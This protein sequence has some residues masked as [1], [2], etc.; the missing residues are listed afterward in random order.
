MKIIKWFFLFSISTLFLACGASTDEQRADAILN[1]MYYIESGDC[2]QAITLLE[3]VGRDMENFF[4][5][6]ALASSYAC[7]A[8]YSTAGLFDDITAHFGSPSLLGGFSLFSNASI[9]VSPDTDSSFVALQE[10]IDILLFAGGV[11]IS[12]E[13][14]VVE[15]AKLLTTDEAG[16]INAFLLY[17]T[18]EQLGKFSY[19]YGNSSGSGVKGSGAA[20]NNCFFDYDLSITFTYESSTVTMDDFLETAGESML[21]T[22]VDTNLAADITTN[23]GHPYLDTTEKKVVMLCR[24]V[25]LLNGFID[26][27]TGVISGAT[28]DLADID[29]TLT[30]AATILVNAAAPG[31]AGILNYSNCTTNFEASTDN[32]QKYFVF[33][34]E[35]L[36]K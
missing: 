5:V 24:G 11:G 20:V 17:L 33:M 8:G 18:M 2:E 13:P 36:L 32:L 23:V 29:D 3:E 14:T 22:C 27:V 26:T 6:E 28:G 12:T 19:Y 31:T 7:K 10:A 16:D 21:G 15:R 35:S 25:T 34:F 30:N 1:A 9:A 4:Y